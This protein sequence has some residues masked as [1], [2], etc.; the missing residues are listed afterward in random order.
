MQGKYGPWW[1]KHYPRLDRGLPE[2]L[3]ETQSVYALGFPLGLSTATHENL[4]EISVRSGA[5]SA[6]RHNN[7]GDVCVIEHSA[8]LEHGNSGG[9]LMNAEGEVVGVNTWTYGDNTNR[10]IS[11]EMLLRFLEE[12]AGLEEEPEAEAA[13]A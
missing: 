11:A 7:D 12:V 6:L 5:V 9:P 3:S 10:A 4:P 8:S 2:D 13:G 1:R